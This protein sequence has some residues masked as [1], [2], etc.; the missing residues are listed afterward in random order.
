MTKREKRRRPARDGEKLLS[1]CTM[2][3][4]ASGRDATGE[5]L[6]SAARSA[7]R[8]DEESR[9]PCACRRCASLLIEA[10]GRAE[11]PAYRRFASLAQFFLEELPSWDALRRARAEGDVA[12]MLGA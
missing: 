11:G 1:H 9:S 10:E 4:L 8:D 7:P 3:V 5:A 2:L 6:L 12:K